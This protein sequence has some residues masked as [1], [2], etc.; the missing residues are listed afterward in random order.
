MIE[1]SPDYQM[2]YS[3]STSVTRS[4]TVI[5]YWCICIYCSDLTRL[6]VTLVPTQDQ[7]ADATFLSRR[8]VIRIIS[9]LESVGL[10]RTLYNANYGNNVY[11]PLKPISSREVFEATFP[12]AIE[13]R[14]KFD[15]SRK[16]DK[17]PREKR[18]GDFRAAVADLRAQAQK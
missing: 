18:Q 3:I 15:A 1:D 7:I 2:K 12:D 9:V 10:I 11:V 4:L 16:A 8:Q 6:R 5:A 14:M 13:K 17:E